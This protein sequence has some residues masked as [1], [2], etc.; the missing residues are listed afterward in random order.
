MA[1]SLDGKV[2][3][4]AGASR[5]IGADI[6]KYLARAGAKVAVCAR[7][8]EVKDP[9]LPGTIHSVT[10]EIKDEGGDAIAIVLNMRDPQSI[11]DAVAK[12]VSEFGKLDILVN[13]AAI[14][15]PGNL[16]TVRENH[17]DL[18]LEVNV[19]SYILTMREVIPHMKAAGGGHIVNISSRGAIPL[20]PGPYTD[21]QKSRGGDIFYGGEKAMLEHFSQR[22]AASYQDDGISV[23]VLSPEGRVA[24]AGNMYASNDRDNPDTNFETA[25]DM[26]QATVWICEQ[27]AEKFTG[28]VTYDK[29]LLTKAGIPHK[30]PFR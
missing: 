3:L 23:N 8:E 20:G 15:V 27:P 6:A 12:V 14:F 25:D 1:G 5:G 2:A 22:M 29:D 19:R 4:V 7:T 18:T 10:K 30:G 13:N 16:E 26:G 24:T 17:I 28:Q 9:R 21:E 11:R